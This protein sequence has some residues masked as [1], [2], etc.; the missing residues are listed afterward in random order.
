MKYKVGDTVRI[1]DVPNSDAI[2]T[3]ADEGGYQLEYLDGVRGSI[4]W[5]DQN[6]ELVTPSIP[7]PIVTETVTR[8]EPGVYGIVSIA[9]NLDIRVVTRKSPDELRAAAD[10]FRALADHYEGQKP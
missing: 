4:I 3:S 10:T 9:D 2:I 1:I 5:N 6:L 8:V 7:S